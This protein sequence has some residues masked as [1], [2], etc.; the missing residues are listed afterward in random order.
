[1]VS[2]GGFGGMGLLKN[3]EGPCEQLDIAGLLGSICA[4]PWEYLLTNSGSGI[5]PSRHQVVVIG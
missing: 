5:P 2:K 4:K 1:M 3:Q